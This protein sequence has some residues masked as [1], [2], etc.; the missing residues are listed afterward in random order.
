MLSEDHWDPESSWELPLAL[1]KHGFLGALF[2]FIF[3]LLLSAPPWE[4]RQAIRLMTSYLTALHSRGDK[5]EHGACHTHPQH[6]HHT[7]SRSSAL[8]LV[9][10]CLPTPRHPTPRK[11]I[12]APGRGLVLSGC[13]HSHLLEINSLPPESRSLWSLESGTLS[14]KI[15]NYLAVRRLPVQ[16]AALPALHW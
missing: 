14:L 9:P 7:L 6:C 12:P 10:K 4:G 15:I 1:R 13:A 5:Q 3:L 2:I 11:D 16:P 8:P